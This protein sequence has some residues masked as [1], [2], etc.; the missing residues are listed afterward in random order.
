L[1]KIV[2]VMMLAVLA[3]APA[4]NTDTGSRT[5]I[6]SVIPDEDYFHLSACAPD[7]GYDLERTYQWRCTSSAAEVVFD[8]AGGTTGTIH[9]V[10]LD[11]AGQVVYEKTFA[12]PGDS[13]TREDT[14]CGFP[15]MWSVQV[16]AAGLKGALVLSATARR[17]VE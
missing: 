9:I 14:A 10:F 4:C 3:F 15:G 16:H 8:S 2:P 6:L 7:G 12:N 1:R 17:T 11:G 13:F 5:S